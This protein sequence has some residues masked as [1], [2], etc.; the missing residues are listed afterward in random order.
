MVK[1]GTTYRI[2]RDFGDRR[3]NLEIIEAYRSNVL[4]DFEV[5]APVTKIF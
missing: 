4:V 1:S 2:P 5:M 3:H